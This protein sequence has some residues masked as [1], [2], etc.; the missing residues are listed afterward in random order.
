MKRF[1][2]QQE[3]LLRVKRQLRG[4]AELSVRQLDS[5]VTRQKK[6]LEHVEDAL[7]RLATG[8]SNHGATQP[9]AAE[10]RN[11]ESARKPIQGEDA[12]QWIN[13]SEQL[14]HKWR[15][16]LQTLASLEAEKSIHVTQLRQL[17]TEIEALETL[18]SQQFESYRK[19]LSRH[20]D[21]VLDEVAL[22]Q[23]NPD[24]ELIMEGGSH[25]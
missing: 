7:H 16:T 6:Q 21:Q 12:W 25:D 9:N 11:G 17:D 8:D 10:F 3:A 24:V 18:R 14:Q 20:Q 5:Q 1:R 13:A 4:R 2:F 22:R 19:E 23:W 15:D